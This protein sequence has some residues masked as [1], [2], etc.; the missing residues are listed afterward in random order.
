MRWHV[1]GDPWPCMGQPCMGQPGGMF[2]VLGTCTYLH[3]IE[4]SI[5]TYMDDVSVLVLDSLA[6]LW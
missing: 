6:V 5:E 2:H 4:C 1:T 3:H